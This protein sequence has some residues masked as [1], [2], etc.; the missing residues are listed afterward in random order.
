[1]DR[2]RIVGGRQLKG[3]IDIGGAKNAALPLMCAALLTGE[4]P[5][6]KRK[7]GGRKRLGKSLKELDGGSQ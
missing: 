6:T 1:M 3:T 4:T 7:T 2:I 5:K